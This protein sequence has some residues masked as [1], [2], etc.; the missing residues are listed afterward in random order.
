MH[1]QFVEYSIVVTYHDAI[2]VSSF[3]FLE[4]PASTETRWTYVHAVSRFAN[5]ICTFD[6]YGV[7]KIAHARV[8][9][10]LQAWFVYR[11]DIEQNW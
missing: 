5:W 10:D 7:C 8:T 11:Y 4:F 2:V 6:A 1:E 9:F 3:M